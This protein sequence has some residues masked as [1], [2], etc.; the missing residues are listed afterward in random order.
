VTEEEMKEQFRAPG[1]APK[2]V[3]NP[4]GEIRHD[5]CSARSHRES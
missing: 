1:W 2:Q 4:A 3:R 5:V